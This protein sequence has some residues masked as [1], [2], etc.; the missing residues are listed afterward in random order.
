MYAVCNLVEMPLSI[1][2]NKDTKQVISL[3]VSASFLGDG[4]L[5]SPAARQFLRGT[6]LDRQGGSGSFGFNPYFT[7]EEPTF[8]HD[9]YIS[10]KNTAYKFWKNN[11]LCFTGRDART[12][13]T[14]LYDGAKLYD[15]VAT[16]EKGLTAEQ[17]SFYASYGSLMTPMKLGSMPPWE[18]DM[19]LDFVMDLSVGKSSPAKLQEKCETL[20]KKVR[21][22]APEHGFFVSGH[23]C[24]KKAGL[25]YTKE[26]VKCVVNHVRKK[27]VGVFFP[28][29]AQTCH[30][31]K[32]CDDCWILKPESWDICVNR[33]RN[34]TMNNK[35]LKGW[36]RKEGVKFEVACRALNSKNL[37]VLKTSTKVPIAD[38]L[39]NGDTLFVNAFAEHS[40]VLSEQETLSEYGD[41]IPNP[42][43]CADNAV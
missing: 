1:N 22:E 31:L 29:W 28:H 39:G 12:R 20:I 16:S 21:S 13:P 35:P 36:V 41:F 26:K 43:K 40:K 5:S 24:G 3:I 9:K 8:Q 10:F 18:F 14:L 38:P 30:D 42:W 17:T 32:D 6:I 19:D 11:S 34:M 4:Y 2:P 33:I 23:A 7:S 25:D 37:K 15:R 27:D